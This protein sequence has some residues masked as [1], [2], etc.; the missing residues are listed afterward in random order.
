M[1]RIVAL[2]VVVSC[3]DAPSSRHTRRSVGSA[4]GS[5]PRQV[6]HEHPLEPDAVGQRA[7]VGLRPREPDFEDTLQGLLD[8]ERTTVYASIA[9][10]LGHG[11]VATR[12]R[13][14]GLTDA[15]LDAVRSRLLAP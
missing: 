1:G 10:A 6:L 11:D 5:E 12:L 4:G 7:E 9:A 2:A 3:G 15:E 13:A 8:R 14:G